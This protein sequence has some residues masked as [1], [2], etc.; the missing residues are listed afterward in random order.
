MRLS[1]QVLCPVR[2]KTWIQGLCPIDTSSIRTGLVEPVAGV[3]EQEQEPVVPVAAVQT[4]SVLGQVAQ[5]H[6]VPCPCVASGFQVH[7]TGATKREALIEEEPS[8]RR[9]LP[10]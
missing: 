6:G 3:R 8:T 5:V 1:D 2:G 9:E 7:P 4:A 10:S